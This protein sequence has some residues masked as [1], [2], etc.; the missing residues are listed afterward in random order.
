M[1]NRKI[2]MVNSSNVVV[3]TIAFNGSDIV[4]QGALA[5]LL[6]EPECFEV[7]PDSKA[8]IGWKYINGVEYSP[9]EV[10]KGL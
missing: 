5:G 4:D 8:S 1:S 9:E 6:S 7:S 2:A 10:D 3:A